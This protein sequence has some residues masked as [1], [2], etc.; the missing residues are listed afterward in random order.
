MTSI[1]D[2]QSFFVFF[3]NYFLYP[4]A[5]YFFSYWVTRLVRLLVGS[6]VPF[7]LG[8]SWAWLLGSWLLHQLVVT[9]VFHSIHSLV[10]LL[11]GFLS[12]CVRFMACVSSPSRV[13]RATVEVYLRLKCYS[14]SISKALWSNESR[15]RHSTHS[16]PRA[17][18][19]EFFLPI[20]QT[21]A[22]NN[23]I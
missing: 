20:I 6:L 7:S 16:Q 8:L 14:S 5:F 21:A 9:W 15:G 2:M 11:V 23:P 13:D 3:F 1:L 17:G 18:L 12:N 19:P 22:K 10:G 4:C